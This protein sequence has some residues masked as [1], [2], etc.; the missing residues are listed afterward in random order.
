[1]NDPDPM[2]RVPSHELPKDE[3]DE[4]LEGSNETIH[5]P[6][7]HAAEHPARDA[8]KIRGPYVTGNY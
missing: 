2:P 6:D 7:P 5:H 3:P 4:N 1:M 8:H